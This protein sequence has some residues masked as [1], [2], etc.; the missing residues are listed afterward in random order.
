[1]P[2]ARS[3][4]HTLSVSA[5]ALLSVASSCAGWFFSGVQYPDRS[6][7]TVLIETSAGVE[8]GVAT[9]AG[10]LFLG[11]TASEGPCRVH[12]YL[13]DQL[14]IEDGRIDRFG[15]VYYR[16]TIDR[17]HQSC[18]LWTS[19]LEPGEV[20]VAQRIGKGGFDEF[21]VR[22]TRDPSVEGD[23]LDEPGVA[24]PVGSGIFKE[25][26]GRLHFVGLVTAAAELESPDGGRRGFVLFTGLD[27]LAE[28]LAVPE[29][30][31]APLRVKYR[32]DNTWVGE[33]T[34]REV[35]RK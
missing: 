22:V 34:P 29:N 8:L 10:I 16:A 13:G 28:A 18:P 27:R 33:P 5:L 25:S 26:A 21:G 11:R 35:D 31:T 1:M 12:Q 17:K 6:R 24:L 23:A 19:P 3:V 7:P 9:S 20:L 15:G 4:R 30:G 14:T 32:S 2:L